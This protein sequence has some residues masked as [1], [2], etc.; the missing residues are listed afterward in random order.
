MI[1]DE[2][3]LSYMNS[4]KLLKQ[5]PKVTA[6]PNFESDLMRRINAG[7]FKGNYKVKWWEKLLLPSRLIPSTALA[8]SLLAVFYIL[9]F[10]SADQ[11]NPFLAKPRIR[12][13]VSQNVSNKLLTA[14]PSELAEA[15]INGSFKINKEGLNFLQ[16]RL[17]DTEKAR[18]NRL[19]QQIRAYFDKNQ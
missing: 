13:I 10:N 5:L 1:Q 11:D 8:L 18:I 4:I 3:D 6:P 2:N 17:N 12:K 14:R 19:K 15:S 9:N 7:N 16:I